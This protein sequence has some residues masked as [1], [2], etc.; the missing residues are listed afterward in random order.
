MGVGVSRGSRY[1]ARREW[2]PFRAEQV[3][4]PVIGPR[5]E[6]WEVDPNTLEPIKK[7]VDEKENKP[8]VQK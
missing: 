5:G 7:V 8:K 3:R 4:D 1:A 6:V 2:K